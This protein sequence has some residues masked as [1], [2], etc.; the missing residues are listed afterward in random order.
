V[1]D[2]G[3]DSRR[4]SGNLLEPA[5]N[6]FG[7]FSSAPTIRGGMSNLYILVTRRI[8]WRAAACAV[9]SCLAAFSLYVPWSDGSYTE[10][11]AVE[12][13]GVW[14]ALV[15]FALAGL[16]SFAA[17]RKSRPAQKYSGVLAIILALLL[18]PYV[19]FVVAF[20]LSPMLG[21]TVFLLLMVFTLAIGI[22]NAISP[23]PLPP[24][25]Q[26][27][28]ARARYHVAGKAAGS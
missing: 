18:G 14:P 11:T 10:H 15:L 6:Y 22:F 13:V 26:L 5:R 25:S 24:R 20:S 21:A 7:N 9:V 27:P 28:T 17:V 12:S 19:F 16:A 4:R 3:R 1:H 8:V 2:D 23:V